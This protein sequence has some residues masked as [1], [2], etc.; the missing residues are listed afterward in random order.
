VLN[1]VPQWASLSL[2]AQSYGATRAARIYKLNRPNPYRRFADTALSLAALEAVAAAMNRRYAELQAVQQ[3]EALETHYAYLRGLPAGTP[4]QVDVRSIEG[5]AY[6][7][8]V[9]LKRPLRP[10]STN[11]DVQNRHGQLWRLPMDCLISEAEDESMRT[12]MRRA[13]DARSQD[14]LRRSLGGA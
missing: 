1:A 13:R 12:A 10:P 7:D 6:G 2:D 5:V 11:I 8:I 14:A 9:T 4:L 3:R